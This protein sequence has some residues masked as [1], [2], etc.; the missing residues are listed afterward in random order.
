M[1]VNLL[2][3]MLGPLLAE[4]V[5]VERVVDLTSALASSVHLGSH[6]VAADTAPSS[7]KAAGRGAMRVAVLS[8]E[9][10][11]DREIAVG[12][13]AVGGGGGGGGGGGPAGPNR[14]DSARCSERELEQ[15]AE[16][17]RPGQTGTDREEPERIVFLTQQER[18]AA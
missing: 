16:R 5:E 10:A 2:Q 14:P 9:R 17:K 11:S 1:T 4:G 15:D 7:G 8:R 13:A 6:A 12:G 18:H 3:G